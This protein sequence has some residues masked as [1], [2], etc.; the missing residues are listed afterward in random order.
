[1]G[2]GGG[3]VV[4]DFTENGNSKFFRREGW[5]GQEPDRVWAIGPRTVLVVPIQAS[6]RPVVLEVELA[7]G[8]AVPRIEGQIVRVTV[9]GKTL[10][11]VRV[12]ARCMIR[13]E[14]DPDLT[15]QD[16]GLSIE[17]GFPGFWRPAEV[18]ESEDGR[19]LSCWF[20]FIRI[21]TMDMF[22]PGPWFP[23]SHPDI[24]IVNLSP[25]F[26]EPPSNPSPVA[27]VAGGQPEPPRINYTFGPDGTAKRFLGDGW[28]EGVDNE[29]ATIASAALLRLPA[30]RTQGA[31]ALRLDAAPVDGQPDVTILLDGIVVGQIPLRERVTWVLPLPRE[32]TE[33]QDLLRLEFMVWERSVAAGGSADGDRGI[34]VS[35]VSVVRLPSHS[36]AV[37]GLRAEQADVSRPMAMSGAFLNDSA[38]DL[39]AAVKAALGI[40]AVTLLGRFESLGTDHEF[41][42]VQ[43]KLGLEVLNLFRFCEGTLAD[44]T[45]ALTDDLMAATDP[46]RVV[47]EADDVVTLPPYN[48]R[49]RMF[50]ERNDTDADGW[51]RTNATTLGYLRRKFYEGLRTGRKIYVLK[52]S[53]PVPAGRAAGLLLELNRGGDATL[54]CVEQASDGRAPGEVELIMPG[55]MRGYLEQSPP[56]PDRETD[57]LADWLRVLANA[58][59][60]KRAASETLLKP[61]AGVTLPKRA[62]RVI[63]VH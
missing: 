55:L 6:C 63:E 4:I 33:W 60:L 1:M 57:A 11:H 41:G 37:E 48:L 54:L 26:P 35:G 44:L 62:D 58:M 16:G 13:I 20:S 61:A 21:Y 14:V 28:G 47:I 51:R 31:Y 3:L 59:L 18:F 29:T 49:W 42:E 53:H 46:D 40:D 24:P 43:G 19:P 30:P 27:G 8:L 32:L 12:T 25:P 10:G 5:S 34:A 7:P 39:P 17:F 56:D 38:T 15:G 22:K 50:G 36:I 2:T 45:R 52:Q 23:T 9:N